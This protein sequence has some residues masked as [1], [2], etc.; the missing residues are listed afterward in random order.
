MEAAH[1]LRDLQQLQVVRDGRRVAPVVELAE[2]LAV[3][4]LLGGV[5]G[6]QIEQSPQERRVADLLHGDD[7]VVNAGVYDGVLQVG[8]PAVPLAAQRRRAGVAAEEQEV[9]QRV[10]ERLAALGVWPR[11]TRRMSS[12]CSG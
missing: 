7:V 4:D 12:A 8:E 3:R 11:G 2:Q 6:A 9:V 5:G 1:Q 10:A